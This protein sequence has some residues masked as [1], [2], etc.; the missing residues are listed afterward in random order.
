M[1]EGEK[2]GGKKG[3]GGGGNRRRNRGGGGMDV[4]ME[5]VGRKVAI[6]SHHA[7]FGMKIANPY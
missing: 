6:I 1:N 4:G 7:E 2:G 5:V 3:S